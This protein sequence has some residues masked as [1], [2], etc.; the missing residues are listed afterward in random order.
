MEIPKFSVLIANYNNARLIQQAL[1]SIKAQ[2]VQ[3]YEVIVVDDGSTDGSHSVIELAKLSFGGKLRHS[4]QDNRGVA[5]ARN[6]ALKMCSG[7]YITFLDPDD[8]W[9]DRRLQIHEYVLD[10][11]PNIGFCCSD[12]ELLYEDG[13]SERH[14]DKW[15]VFPDFPFEREIPR[16]DALRWLL[17]VNF[18]GTNGATIRRSCVENVGLFKENYRQSEDY[19]YW[20]RCAANSEFYVIPQVLHTYRIHRGGLTN[21]YL[22]NCEYSQ[23]AVQE[24]AKAYSEFIR[25]HGLQHAVKR[26]ISRRWYEIGN[27]NFENGYLGKAYGSYF[28]GLQSDMSVSN[29]LDFL[30]VTCRKTIRLAAFGIC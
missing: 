20:L 17:R 15:L 7:E 19:D 26:S 21:N 25:Y 23:R 22:E 8:Y 14:F 24:C 16:E 6:A 13:R 10:R 9:H 27:L 5:S 18:V 4:F 30:S 2:T 3:N 28:A 12:F 1:D 11:N 29:I